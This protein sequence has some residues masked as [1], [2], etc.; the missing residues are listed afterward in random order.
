[1]NGIRIPMSGI[2]FLLVG[3][4]GELIYLAL[5]ALASQAGLG[6][7]A[8]ITLAG[9]VCLGL[10]AFLHARI[11]F[12]VTYRWSLLRDYLAVQLLCLAL[13]LGAGALL[14]RLGVSR[15]VIAVTT[16]VLWGGISFLLT[17][18]RFRQAP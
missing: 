1:M 8:A 14:E 16:M 11:S 17:R 6:T 5:Y 9:G 4:V 15:P 2:R 13:A 10:N 12:R 3:A 7:M 18:W